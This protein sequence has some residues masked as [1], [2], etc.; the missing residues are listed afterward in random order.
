MMREE[1]SVAS[2]LNPVLSV[3]VL[4]DDELLFVDTV[5]G[6]PVWRTLLVPL[7]AL[8]GPEGLLAFVWEAGLERFW[9]MPASR[10][11]QSITWFEAARNRWSVL[12]HTDVDKQDRAARILFLPKESR[13][14]Q[15]RQLVLLFPEYAGWDWKLSTTR[16]LL[17]T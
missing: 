9:V 15:T 16:S 14:R 11:S 7:D 5:Q 1:A 6:K 12:S 17:A 8:E 3:G 10:F 4:S 2:P 13:T